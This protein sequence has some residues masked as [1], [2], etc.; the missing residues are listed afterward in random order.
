ML[1]SMCHLATP[2]CDLDQPGGIC[3]VI[4]FVEAQWLSGRLPDSRS[5]GHR[6]ESPTHIG[7][8]DDDSLWRCYA[9]QNT[10]IAP[11]YFAINYDLLYLFTT[12]LP[13]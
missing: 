12:Q 10:I 11:L 2:R 5:R 13:R 4:P 8:V 6:H 1:S 7:A 3:R 9:R